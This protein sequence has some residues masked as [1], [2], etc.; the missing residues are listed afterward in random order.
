MQDL[1]IKQVDA[2]TTKPFSGNPAGV[3][4]DADGLGIEMMQA[5][6]GEMNLTETAFVTVP[7]AENAMFRLRFFTPTEEVDLSGHA[8]IATCYA[9]IEAGRI[10]LSNGVTRIHLETNIGVVLVDIYFHQRTKANDTREMKKEGIE[11][12]QEGEIRGTLEK[13]MM[14][15]T[16]PPYRRSNIPVCDIASILC[17]REDEILKTGMPLEIISTGL[18][19]LMIP[20]LHKETILDMHPD[21]IK[22]SLMN[23]KFGIHTNH[24]FTTDTFSP[25]CVS[26]SRHFAPAL[27]MWEDP[28]TGTAAAG[29][30]T[31]LLRH[32]IITTDSMIMEQGKET[33]N[34]A[35]ILV[36]IDQAGGGDGSVRIGGLAVTSIARTINM[37]EGELVIN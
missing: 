36:E 16:V 24:I 21:L 10:P 28:A 5:I 37:R 20:V 9:L 34:L 35:R 27:G 4:T 15:Y 12:I 29:L 30:G 33:E 7:E 14:H 22:L 1:I 2:F 18:E 6:A 3:I 23:R 32:G 13:M 25:E 26:Y 17:V 8:T 19:Q 11:L 31:Y